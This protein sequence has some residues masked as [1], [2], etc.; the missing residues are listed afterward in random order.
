MELGD[1]ESGFVER[2]TAH[3]DS[4]VDLAKRNHGLWPMKMCLRD[5]FTQLTEFV[6]GI[7]LGFV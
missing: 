2:Q 7:F 5:F 3:T 4:D 6:D 1:W